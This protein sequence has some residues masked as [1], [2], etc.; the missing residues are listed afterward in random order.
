MD[1]RQ[2]EVGN[3]L[4]AAD[5]TDIFNP[6]PIDKCF[7]REA[8]LQRDASG[9][10]AVIHLVSVEYTLHLSAQGRLNTT[11]DKQM[12]VLLY[13]ELTCRLPLAE[14]KYPLHEN[15][16]RELLNRSAPSKLKKG[17]P[18]CPRDTRP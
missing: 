15:W 5:V 10:T 9:P 12:L 8:T 7:N 1:Q 18:R 3:S 16:L 14:G 4:A 17:A 13:T 6:S 2:T 11:S